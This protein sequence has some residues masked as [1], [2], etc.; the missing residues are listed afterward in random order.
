MPTISLRKSYLIEALGKGYADEEVA[1]LMM[2]YGL[3]LDDIVTEQVDEYEEATLMKTG[4]QVENVIYKI[5][6]PANRH[7]LL[8][9][10]G[11]VSSLLQYLE[12]GKEECYKVS[13]VRNEDFVITVKEEVEGQ[14]AVRPF[15]V[16][17]VLKD[18]TLN[19][20]VVKNLIDLQEKLH[21]NLCRKRTLV[22]IGTHDL[23]TIRGPFTYEFKKPEDIKFIPLNDTV[24]MN[25]PEMFAKFKDTHLGEYLPLLEGKEY[26]PVVYDSN[27]VICS[28]PPII[29]GNHSK[30]TPQTKNIL[31]ECT[32]TDLEKCQSTIKTVAALFSKYCGVKN[33]TDCVTVKLGNGD[34]LVTPDFRDRVIVT[35]KVDVSKQLGVEL[36][37]DEIIALLKRMGH[38]VGKKDGKLVVRTPAI[39]T[40]VLAECDIIEDVGIAYGYDNIVKTQPKSV[41]CG[42]SLPLNTVTEK[43]RGVMASMGYTEALTFAL[44]SKADISLVPGEVD[45]NM[46]TIGNPKTK[47]CQAL[48]T[49]LFAGLLKTLSHN[50][51]VPMPIKL[52]EIQDVVV[53]DP[54]AETGARNVRKIGVVCCNTS[55]G[56]EI[57]RGVL[58]QILVALNYSP[59]LLK[60]QPGQN[61]AFFPDR[62]CEIVG[63]N[64]KIIGHV[65]CLHPHVLK[66]FSL[67]NP[68]C[69]VEINLEELL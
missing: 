66:Q 43:L 56:Y 20:F 69:G 30:I 2:A 42:K 8:C 9:H 63:E 19:D 36:G 50:K 3:E 46:V 41:S 58:D 62:Y 52:F 11:L 45:E 15:I 57:A 23:D 55:A 32:G 22:A 54:S 12:T 24:E 40:D 48:R 4:K 65:G 64:N 68:V 44:L 59:A 29:N 67:A 53:K 31:I 16:G 14:S 38:S 47:D 34:E 33:V 13:D 7:D 5:D 60:I 49:N 10:E 27:N 17:A 1:N 25:A 6:I 18:V 39:R 61:K 21:Q 35:D 26:Y 37:D 28:L 51:T